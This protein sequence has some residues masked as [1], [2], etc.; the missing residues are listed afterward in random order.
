MMYEL[1]KPGYYLN[2]SDNL[3]IFYPKSTFEE[4]KFTFEIFAPLFSGEVSTWQK[5]HIDNKQLNLINLCNLF[6]FIEDL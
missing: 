2:E 3:L 1:K 5:V 6:Y 4:G